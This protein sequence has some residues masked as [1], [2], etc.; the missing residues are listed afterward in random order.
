MNFSILFFLVASQILI[1]CVLLII[2]SK[3]F[4]NFSFDHFFVP[5]VSWK[6]VDFPIFR[7][8]LDRFLLLISTLIPPWSRNIPGLTRVLLSLLRL[9]LISKSCVLCC[10]W[11][12]HSRNVS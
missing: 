4:I 6:F 5:K 7:G 12:E 1:C 11:V 3:Y 10:S 2:S 9:V 8:F